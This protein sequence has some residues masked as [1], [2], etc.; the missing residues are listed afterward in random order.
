MNL[1][2]D[3]GDAVSGPAQQCSIKSCTTRISAILRTKFSLEKAIHLF[4]TAIKHNF[5]GEM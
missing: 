3:A 2:S 1:R 4:F 5:F